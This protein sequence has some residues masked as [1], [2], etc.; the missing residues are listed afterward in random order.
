LLLLAARIAFSVPAFK[1]PA[2]KPSFAPPF[3][4]NLSA[5]KPS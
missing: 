3:R 4:V 1:P 5:S 2:L